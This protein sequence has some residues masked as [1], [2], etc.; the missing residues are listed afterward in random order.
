MEN[1]SQRELWSRASDLP[2]KESLQILSSAI[3]L[4]DKAP[5]METLLADFSNDY[6]K[7]WHMAVGTYF[8]DALDI[9]Q[10]AKVTE[11]SNTVIWTQGGTFSFSQGDML[12]DTPL[13]HQQWDS[14]LQ[15]IQVAYQVLEGTPSRPEKQQVYFRKTANYTGSLAGDRIRAKIPRREAILKVATTDWTEVEKLGALV[16]A[17]TRSYVSPD[18]LQTLCELGAMERKVEVVAPRFPGHIKI[19]IMAPN[20][21]RSALC[22]KSEMTMSQDEFMEFLI[23]GQRTQN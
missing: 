13:A 2:Q 21:D 19:Q 8:R 17:A 1:T 15:H 10:T 23:T 6:A 18:L 16:K 12:Y 3:A 9:K 11:E 14:A 20:P 7:G 5:R 22:A 4:L